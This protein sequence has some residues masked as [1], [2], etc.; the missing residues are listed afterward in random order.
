M[1]VYLQMTLYIIVD[2][3]VNAAQKLHVDLSKL[4]NWATRF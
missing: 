1:F 4:H 2:T 3:P